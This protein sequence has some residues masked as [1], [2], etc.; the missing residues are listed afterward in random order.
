MLTLKEFKEARSVLSGVIRNTSLVYS[1]A[2][3]KTTG[4]HV[5]IKPENMQVTGAYKIR[6]AYYKIS[7]LT[8]EE[9]A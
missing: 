7:T 5:Y 6:G 4:N 9:K 2:F 3:S 1:T 8:E